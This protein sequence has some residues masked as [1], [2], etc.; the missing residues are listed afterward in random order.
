MQAEVSRLNLAMLRHLK[1]R[2]GYYTIIYVGTSEG[3]KSYSKHVDDNL[4]DEIVVYDVFGKNLLKTNL[5][6]QTVQDRAK[7]Q[8]QKYDTPFGVMYMHR[9]ETGLGYSLGGVNHPLSPAAKHATQT[10]SLHAFSEAIDFWEQEIKK[11]NISLFVN[12]L[13]VEAVVARKHGIPFRYFYATRYK[14]FYFWA[15]NEFIEFPRIEDHY[16]MIETSE[17]VNMNQQYYQDVISKTRYKSLSPEIL[18]IKNILNAL[19]RFIYVKFKKYDDSSQYYLSERINYYINYYWTQK[20]IIKN[21]T[22]KLSDLKNK[23]FIYFPLQTEPEY[24]LQ[25]M[26]PEYF[27]QLETIAKI[28]RDLPADVTLVVKEAVYSYGRRPRDFYRTLDLLKN[29]E[30]M[31]PRE[32]GWKVAQ[33]ADAVANISGTA[34]LEAALAGVPVISFGQH[35]NYDFLDHVLTVK[36][37]SQVREFLVHI[38]DGHVDRDKARTDGAKLASALERLSI[39]M[40][41]FD[42]LNLESYNDEQVSKAVDALIDSLQKN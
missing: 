21:H 14:N 18:I 17:D 12:H 38:F 2:Y 39:D 33:K 3:V 8:E 35:N 40:E 41:K 11:K 7:K 15:E 19:H 32:P 36:Q 25:A 26:S 24:S 16:K 23:K 29:V 9:R 37:E 27:Y 42:T 34:N 13:K 22:L 6:Q 28:S 1:Q 4:I 10:Q 20:K 31:D 5:N 30:L